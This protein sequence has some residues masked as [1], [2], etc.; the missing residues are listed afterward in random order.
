MSRLLEGVDPDDCDDLQDATGET[1]AFIQERREELKSELTKDEPDP[2]KVES[3]REDLDEIG[4][5]HNRLQKSLAS[6]CGFG[7]YPVEE[8]EGEVECDDME[9]WHSTLD[10]MQSDVAETVP[11]YLIE[12]DISYDEEA[13]FESQKQSF[14]QSAEKTRETIE[15]VADDRGC[16]GDFEEESSNPI[17]PK[18]VVCKQPD[19][20]DRQACL[21]DYR[22]EDTHAT[23]LTKSGQVYR[24]E[25]APQ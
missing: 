19:P 7:F 1:D 17:G 25:N 5:V 11:E 24:S 21:A 20:E 10:K 12:D 4:A 2:E 16:N 14:F 15:E 13:D 23:G 18:T 9:E 22:G 6:A 3:I 8:Y